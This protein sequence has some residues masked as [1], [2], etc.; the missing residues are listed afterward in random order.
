VNGGVELVDELKPSPGV[1]LDREASCTFPNSRTPLHERGL[2]ELEY[3]LYRD[4]AGE[5]A[6]DVSEKLATGLSGV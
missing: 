1:G 2:R 4:K 3:R 6:D 5:S